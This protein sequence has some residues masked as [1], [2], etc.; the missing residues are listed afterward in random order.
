MRFIVYGA[1][2]IG[3]VIGGRLCEHGHDV[4]LVARGEHATTLA[5]SGLVIESPTG[6]TT[7]HAPVCTDADQV[8]WTGGDVVVLAVKSQDSV[9]VLERL[10]RCAPPETPIVCAQNGVTNELAALRLF[11]NVIATNV[12][13]P[14]THLA[15]GVVQANCSP[16]SGILG[17]GRYP[18]GIDETC[19]AVAAALERSTFVSEPRADI[20]RWKY[21]K[22]MMNLANAI[23]AVCGTGH[24]TGPLADL[25]RAEGRACLAA[26]RLD[27]ATEDEERARRGELLQVRP[28]AGQ[29]R[30]GGSTWQS[31]VRGGSVETDHLNGEIVLLGRLHGVP[32]PANELLR[33]LVQRVAGEGRAPGGTTPDQV[34]AMLAAE[35]PMSHTEETD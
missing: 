15:P 27:V 34:L 12:M 31:I 16:I 5:R 28:I 33:H 25:V 13:C 6:T 18:Q 19:V 1:G 29:R 24:G 10:R 11:P 35:Q 20:M 2:A 30:G 7:V 23:E 21:S 26:A 14:A 9:G 3:G 32:T 8:E 4:V 22:L 17:V